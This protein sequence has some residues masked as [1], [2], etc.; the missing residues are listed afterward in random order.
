MKQYK[1]TILGPGEHTEKDVMFL[2][3]IDGFPS[4]MAHGETEAD[5]F[6]ALASVL[7][8]VADDMHEEGEDLPQTPNE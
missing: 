2:A 8:D 6:G 7:M 5:A 1:I 3:K 4:L